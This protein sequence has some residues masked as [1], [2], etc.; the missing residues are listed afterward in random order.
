MKLFL[1]FLVIFGHILDREASPSRLMETINFW[2]Y[3]FHMSAFIFVSG[4]FSKHAIKQRKYLRLLSFVWLYLLAKLLITL[5]NFA[6]ANKMNFDLLNETGVPWYLLSLASFYL[7][8]IFLQRVQPKIMLPIIIVIG[9]AS[10][11]LPVEGFL[12]LGRT[13]GFFPFFYCGYLMDIQKL[14]TFLDHRKVKWAAVGVIL[15]SFL[16]VNSQWSLATKFWGFLTGW[17]S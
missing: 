11:Y 7:I 16:F 8:T 17:A 15:S 13:L 14:Q 12:S 4:L 6:F 5:A 10:G 3:S 9:C 1:I 2:I